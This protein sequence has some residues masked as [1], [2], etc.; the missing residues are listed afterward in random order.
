M[1]NTDTTKN[2]IM[3]KEIDIN[4]LAELPTVSDLLEGI[5]EDVKKA[6]KA[7]KSIPKPTDENWED[8]LAS[9]KVKF[10]HTYE[11]PPTC[12]EIIDNNNDC[13]FGTLG[14]FSAVI[15]KAKSGKTYFL[16][17]ILSSAKSDR[18]DPVSPV[19]MYP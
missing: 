8:V 6:E 18:I 19:L 1:L 11:Q 3:N 14:N 16:T 5:Y 15:G 13:R 2:N 4:N 7:H 12:I 9:L 10:D 17:F